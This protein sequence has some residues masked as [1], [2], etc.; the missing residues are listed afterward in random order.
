V[1]DVTKPGDARGRLLDAVVAHVADHGVGDLSLRRLASG[2]GTSHRMLL[3]HFGSKEQLLVEIVREVER[4]QRAVMAEL[5]LD[6]GLGTEEVA[7][8]LWARLADRSMWPYERLFFEVYARALQGDAASR[9]L[10][11]GIVESWVEPGAAALRRAGLP[12]PEARA[13]A[14]LGVAVTRGLLLDLLAT[15]DRAGVDAAMEV[16]LGAVRPV[17]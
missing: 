5:D 13:R 8:R 16:F 17:R 3:Y 1:T 6:P 14:R 12:G 4:R 11:E 7:R 15:E 9:P 10:L 2:L